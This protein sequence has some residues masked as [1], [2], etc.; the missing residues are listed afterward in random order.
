MNKE[1][2]FPSEILSQ[3]FPVHSS[4]NPT[5]MLRWQCIQVEF[6]CFFILFFI[7]W[8]S[9]KNTRKEADISSGIIG[10]NMLFKSL[11]LSD[12][13][14]FQD[15]TAFLVALAV[16]SGK[17]IDPTQFAV[18]VLA[19]H[20]SNHVAASE[21]DPILN[22]TILQIYHLIKKEG[23]SCGP[24]KASW[25]ELRAVGQDCITVC[26][27]EQTSATN[28]VQ[29]NSAHFYKFLK[30][31][32]RPMEWSFVRVN[33][34]SQ[35]RTQQQLSNT[36]YWTADHTQLFTF[37]THGKKIKFKALIMSMGGHIFCSSWP[38][39]VKLFEL[40]RRTINLIA[41]YFEVKNF[42]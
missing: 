5:L 36:Q 29:E 41:C 26:T 21:H 32:S 2:K 9:L 7:F 16:F 1:R 14:S 4:M 34:F 28:M 18:A 27:G 23:S 10:R 37:A 12:Q 31:D 33:S 3:S 35:L 38:T 6:F 25:Y 22:F 19:A 40:I 20:V 13:S 39:I 8:V 11:T 42:I 17:F 15:N 30:L 24:C